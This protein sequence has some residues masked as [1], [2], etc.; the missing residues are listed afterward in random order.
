M[1]ILS[2]SGVASFLFNRHIL[3]NSDGH[4]ICYHLARDIVMLIPKLPFLQYRHG[5]FMP[6]QLGRMYLCAI[7]SA[8]PSASWLNRLLLIGTVRGPIMRYSLF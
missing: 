1:L 3:R 4:S 6:Y 8:D 5:R 2:I 7:S